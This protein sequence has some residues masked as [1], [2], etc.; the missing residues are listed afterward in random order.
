[1]RRFSRREGNPAH[2]AQISSGGPPVMLIAEEQTF[3][4]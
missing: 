1:V 3:T 4:F 2:T